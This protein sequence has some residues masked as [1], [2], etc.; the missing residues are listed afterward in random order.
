QREAAGKGAH[1]DRCHDAPPQSEER[2]RRTGASRI[3]LHEAGEPPNGNDAIRYCIRYTPGLGS[4]YQPCVVRAERMLPCGRAD[5]AI[6]A[7]AGGTTKG[8]LRGKARQLGFS[9]EAL[10]HAM[11]TA[12]MP[13]DLEARIPGSW[14]WLSGASRGRR[15][16][17]RSVSRPPLRRAGPKPLTR[18]GGAEGPTEHP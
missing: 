13:A 9:H 10:R 18:L 16:R 1:L 14:R 2:L 7:V 8:G 17:R 5:A 3:Y 15:S 4:G 12:G 6:H 11:R